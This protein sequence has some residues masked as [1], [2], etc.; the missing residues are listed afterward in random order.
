M[1]TAVKDDLI[2]ILLSRLHYLIT[3]ILLMSVYLCQTEIWV[4]GTDEVDF[5]L[6]M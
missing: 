2:F 4:F 6:G 5:N 1:V 3:I